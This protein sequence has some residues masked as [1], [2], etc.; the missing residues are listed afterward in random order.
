[1]DTICPLIAVSL[2][3]AEFVSV[4]KHA[5]LADIRLM[6]L[7]VSAVPEAPF[8]LPPTVIFLILVLQSA[9]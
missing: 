3:G 2:C 1:M 4:L 9:A 8:P 6:F 5:D 7:Y